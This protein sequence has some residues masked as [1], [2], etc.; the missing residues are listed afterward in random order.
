M[1][2]NITYS[3]YR[4]TKMVLISNYIE[5]NK[6]DDIRKEPTLTEINEL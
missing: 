1:N 2:F 3:L 6:I 5:R 4:L